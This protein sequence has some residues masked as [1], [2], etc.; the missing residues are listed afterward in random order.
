MHVKYIEPLRSVAEVIISGE[1]DIVDSTNRVIKK[2]D[3]L[4]R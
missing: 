2:I 1:L 3:L 4:T